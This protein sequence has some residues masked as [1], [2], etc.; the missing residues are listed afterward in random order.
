MALVAG[1]GRPGIIS[2]GRA[3]STLSGAPPGGFGLPGNGNG[4]YTASS[5]AAWPRFGALCS[6]PVVCCC[7]GPWNIAPGERQ[8]LTMTWDAW[9]QS[10]PGYS[11]VGVAS[12]SLW[13]MTGVPSPEI[14]DPTM[15]KVV[16]GISGKDPEEPD[17]SDV[18]DLIGMLPQLNGT[19]TLIE[20]AP[21]APLGQQF[22]LDM[23]IEAC[24]GCR[25]REIRMCDCFVI[26]IQEC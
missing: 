15:I 17:N 22:K 25:G 19:Q 18:A 11:L 7:K 16:S 14:A 23:C 10:V 24:E 9:L 6:P 3:I 13:R 1:T 5:P 21:D 12:A 20:V 2:A 8:P 4:F 26:V